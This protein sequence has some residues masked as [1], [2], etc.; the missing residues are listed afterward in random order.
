MNKN[1]N[2]KML[3]LYT[4][5]QHSY[6][7]CCSWTLPGRRLGLCQAVGQYKRLIIMM[8]M[9]RTFNYD[10]TIFKRHVCFSGVSDE[11]LTSVKYVN[12][13]LNVLYKEQVNFLVPLSHVLL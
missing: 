5:K 4:D 8:T 10:T 12:V 3:S 6:V 2:I 13:A 9:I 7:A 11:S 1:A